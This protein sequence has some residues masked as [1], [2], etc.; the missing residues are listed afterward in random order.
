M[1]SQAVNHD[2]EFEN[3]TENSEGKQLIPVEPAKTI[4]ESVGTT[5]AGPKNAV[6]TAPDDTEGYD[7]T[8]RLE[9]N[10]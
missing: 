2:L 4:K 3:N 1:A 10:I 8:G 5:N 7:E 9:D 6:E